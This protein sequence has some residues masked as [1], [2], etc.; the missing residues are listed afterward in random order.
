MI[1]QIDSVWRISNLD[2]VIRGAVGVKPQARENQTSASLS[3]ES[4][5]MACIRASRKIIN[6]NQ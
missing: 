3:W 4:A 1:R 6:I 2:L 5:C